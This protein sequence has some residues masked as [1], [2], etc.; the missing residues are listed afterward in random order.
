MSVSTEVIIVGA[1]P[2]GL[3]AALRLARAGVRVL[4]LEGAD[5]AGAENWSGSVCHAEP[6]LRADV[7][8]ADLWAQAPR[9]RRIVARSLLFHDGVHV[10]GFEARANARNDYGE[11]WTVLRPR[12]DR[13]L[14]ARAVDAGATLLPATTVTGLRY[15]GARV[16]GVYT[17]RGPIDAEI[18]LLAEGDAAGLLA[19]EGLEQTPQPHYAQGI[20]AVFAL[21]P[22]EIERRFGL[23][24]GEGI[25]QEWILRNGRRDGRLARLNATAFLYTNRDSLSVGLVLPLKALS[26]AGGAD[27]GA[28]FQRVTALSGIAAYLTNAE[29]VAYGAK[30]IRAGGVNETPVWTRDGLAVIGGALGLGQ[31]FP[32]PNFIGPAMAS[33]VTC[34]DAILRVRAASG[35]FDAKT[36]AREYAEPLRASV[37]YGNAEVLRRW[38]QALQQGGVIFERVPALLGQF[39]P[40]E[41]DN[42]PAESRALAIALGQAYSD[43]GQLL[44]LRRGI[45]PPRKS[46]L[47]PAPL[48]VRFLRARRGEVPQPFALKDPLAPLLAETLGI[49]YGRR[50]PSIARRLSAMHAAY[51]R[52]RLQTV[53]RAARLFAQAVGGAAALLGDLAA[54]RVRRVS[55]RE[56]TLRPFHRHEAASHKALAWAR[57]TQATPLNWIAPLGRAL[58]DTRHIALPVTLP[59]EAALKLQ[60]VCPAVVYRPLSRLGG[61]ESQFENCIKCESCRVQVPGIDWNRTSEHRLAYRLPNDSRFGFDGSVRSAIQQASAARAS[62]PPAWQAF[63]RSLQARPAQLGP[64]WPARLAQW[65]DSRPRDELRDDARARLAGW[66]A[67]GRYGWTAS[68]VAAWL[69]LP[70]HFRAAASA[71]DDRAAYARAK[72]QFNWSALQAVFTRARLKALAHT[73]WQT[74]D[75]QALLAWLNDA[76]TQTPAAL[77]WLAEWAPA[78]AWVALNHRLAE[79]ATGDTLP[80]LAAVL[81][82]AIDGH[83]SWVPGVAELYVDANGREV[84]AGAVV[85]HG[86]GYDAAQPVRFAVAGPMPA[87]PVDAR[88][89]QGLLAIALGNTRA[90]HVRVRE[91]VA[92]RVQFAGEFADRA[93]HDGI[94]K[95][96]AVKGMLATLEYALALFEAIAPWCEREPRRVLEVVQALAGVAMDGGPWLAGQ[97]FGGMAYSEEEI[98]APRYRDAMVLAQWPGSAELDAGQADRYAGQLFA[99]ADSLLTQRELRI[100]AQM[101]AQRPRLT[102]SLLPLAAE[103]V[104]VGAT[105]PKRGRALDWAPQNKF[106]YR[107]G[108]FFHGQ[109]LDDTQLLTPEHYRRNPRL[110]ATRAAVLRL[111]RSGFKAPARG[112][113]YG[114]YIDS[115]HGVPPADVERLRAFNAFATIVPER[116]GGKGWTK[117]DYAVMNLLTMGHGDPSLGLLIMASTSIGTMPVVL[118]LEQD[119]PRLQRELDANLADHSAW[120]QLRAD[121]TLL[122]EMLLR[123]EPTALKRVLT[124]L[125]TRV[126]ATFMRPG[127]TLKYLARDFLLSLQQVVEVAKARDLEALSQKLKASAGALTRARGILEAEREALP[128]RIAAHERFMR[129]LAAG[130]IS[131]FALTEPVAGSD[132]GGIQ[133]RAVLRSVPVQTDMQGFYR[134][135][136]H[137][138][139][140][141]RVLIDADRLMFDGRRIFYRLAS[142]QLAELDDSG[143]D[144]ARNTGVRALRLGERRFEFHDIGRVVNARGALRYDYWELT[145]NKMWITNGSIADRYVIYSQTELGPTGFMLERRSEGLRIGPNENKLGQRASPT[146]ELALERVRISADQVVGFRGHGQV[147]ALETLSVGRGGLVT[148]CAAF[149]ERALHAYAEQWAQH[150][151]LQRAAWFELDRIQTLAARLVGLMDR[152]DLSEGDFRIEA[153]LSKYLASEGLHRVLG[154]LETIRGPMAAA[155]EEPIEKW[156]R[157]ARILNIYEG[158]NEVQRFLVLKDLPQVLARS[159]ETRMDNLAL[160]T[161]LKNFRDAVGPHIARLGARVWQDGDLQARWFGV[162]EWAGELYAWCA[163]HERLR[164]LERGADP[165]DRGTIRRLRAQTELMRIHV[166]QYAAYIGGQLAAGEASEQDHATAVLALARQALQRS[167]IPA[168]RPYWLGR[169]RGAFACVLRAKW[170]WRDSGPHFEGWL[171]ED[172]AVLDCLL[173]ARDAGAVPSVYVAVIA[174]RGLDDVLKRLNA[175]GAEVL[176]LAHPLGEY[177]APQVAAAMQAAWPT[178]TRFAFGYRAGSQQERSF[179]EHLAA[180]LGCESIGDVAAVGGAAR[181]DWIETRGFAR[182]YCAQSRKLA[183]LW[184]LKPTGRADRFSVQEWL[185]AL[186]RDILLRELPATGRQLRPR[187]ALAARDLPQAFTTPHE[188]AV[189]LKSYF[190]G[191]A[192]SEPAARIRAAQAPLPPVIALVAPGQLGRARAVPA[193]RLARELNGGVL[194]WNAGRNSVRDGRGIEVSRYLADA[195]VWLLDAE[196]HDLAAKLPALLAQVKT[197]IV[198]GDLRSLAAQLAARLDAPLIDG[199]VRVEARRVV[200]IHPH[201]RASQALSPLAV[202]IAHNDCEASELQPNGDA[203]AVSALTSHAQ[204][205]AMARWRAHALGARKSGLANAPVI[206]DV[207]HGA[208]AFFEHDVPRLRA[209][210]ARAFDTDVVIGATRKITQEAKL[211]AAEAQIGQT[212]IAVAPRLLL[213]LGVSGAPQ[214]M[215]WIDKGAIVLA[216]NRDAD[217][218]IFRW[219]SDHGGPHVIRCVGD[220]A[221]WLP[222][223]AATLEDARAASDRDAPRDVRA[224]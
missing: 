46:A 196:A 108:G 219:A 126:Q 162:V 154:W 128:A 134:F 63:Y 14:A 136:P 124:R 49:F 68:E 85:A 90:L 192:G 50:E 58:P 36:L 22:A 18:V 171:E 10:A 29:Q 30:V 166:E 96:G 135:V 132:T 112:A 203:V 34:A 118:A 184:D 9:E 198:D 47:G 82:R 88:L 222:A 20:K 54:Y 119:L 138:A 66:L 38:P 64:E 86:A 79:A 101:R 157:D 150:A 179:A 141:P 5:Y 87:F 170:V 188:A 160:D 105:V 200:S 73:R 27:H 53:T 147:N 51:R 197:L 185:D 72:T 81:A 116:L 78:L 70:Q 224:Q 212:G 7:L 190:G 211:M 6:L 209:A 180:L 186:Q 121:I 56:L 201:Y 117:A 183:L 83:S 57:N 89:A 129:F 187:I 158:T 218:P 39:V 17:E 76:A 91:Y 189:W 74:Q 176:H 110:R 75:R 41:G 23:G 67:A 208:A 94:A 216:I 33:A 137:G 12:L 107:S 159:A 69:A 44:A 115:L 165:A 130:Q 167:D 35:S 1:G 205:G 151:D 95:F 181:G 65:V 92:Q 11:A 217:A 19:R 195:G 127:S 98:F 60:R 177:D 4:V 193:I 3:A 215:G 114:R 31:E 206:L 221:Q 207:G 100:Y 45:W 61:A 161:A 113:S 133:T 111:L 97:A 172:R 146:N 140:A 26:E 152:A 109:I 15:D 148:G 202:L 144:P 191:S 102:P 123:P 214:H 204:G 194:S 28:L 169:L 223:L 8:G 93:G 139:S 80:R 199:V 77:A 99:E 153:A 213:A 84:A 168:A 32:Y 173:T 71:V 104:H 156:R 42:R 164:F 25:A 62:V 2:G 24:P 122:Q 125:G 103:A 220:L 143:W 155:L 59:P 21:S 142:E 178:L 13:W 55:L 16:V 40:G 120:A 145:G 106:V 48:T 37:D 182:R 210:L 174:P 163:L 43:I 149:I 175:A 52:Q 131:A